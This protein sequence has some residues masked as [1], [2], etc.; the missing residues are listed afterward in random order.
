[1]QI[2]GIAINFDQVDVFVDG[3]KLDSSA[4]LERHD[5]Q[6]VVQMPPGPEV[7]GFVKVHVE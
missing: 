5:E 2:N 1:M 4:I 3:K 7:G 6:L